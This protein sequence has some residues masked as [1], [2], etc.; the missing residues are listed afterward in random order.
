MF[1][2][3]CLIASNVIFVVILLSA[4]S[5]TNPQASRDMNYS[6][7]EGYSDIEQNISKYIDNFTYENK[8]NSYTEVYDDIYYLPY[9]LQ[10]APYSLND[11]LWPFRSYTYPKFYAENLQKYSK[12]WY[13]D[14]N[15]SAHFEKYD[16]LRKYAV[17][18]HFTN[19]RSFPTDK[20]LF[21]DPS[22]AGEGFPF[23]YLQNSAIH[24]NEPLYVSHFNRDKS[25]VYV[26]SSYANGWVKVSD[27]AFIPKKY[28]VKIK[29]AQKAYI[30]KERFPIYNLEGK[31]LFYGRIGMSF[32]IIKIKEKSYYLTI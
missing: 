19:L 26:F 3:F 31:F 24:A 17:T 10:Q 4:C 8:T 30:I 6:N 5:V 7:I 21:L 9:T 32:A 22:K 18:L 2:R 29:D 25:W 15:R 13:Q 11:I 1:F 27:I 23:D 28:A 12:K 20:P 14:Q 16:S